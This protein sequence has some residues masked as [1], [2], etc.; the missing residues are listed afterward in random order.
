MLILITGTL[1]LDDLLHTSQVYKIISSSDVA[2]IYVCI[3]SGI[4][5]APIHVF[6]SASSVCI[7]IFL[8]ITCMTHVCHVLYCNMSF[9]IVICYC[10][11]CYCIYA[12]GTYV[13]IVTVFYCIPLNSIYIRHGYSRFV[14]R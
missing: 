8:R 10:I 1:L 14:R 2:I 12:M 9:Y 3:Y 4:R 6:N 7:T 5:Y 11:V 13:V